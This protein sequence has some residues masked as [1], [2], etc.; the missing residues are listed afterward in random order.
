MI[1]DKKEIAE[2]FNEHF[3]SI[4]DNVPL[5]EEEDYG[6]DFANH[7]SIKAIFENGGTDE[8]ACFSKFITQVNLT[9]KAY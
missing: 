2:L 6:E 9:L 8:L 5:R 3:V 7:Q 4:A 1:T